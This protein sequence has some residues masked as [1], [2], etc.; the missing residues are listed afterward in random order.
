MD[1]NLSDE[2]AKD[3]LT[4]LVAVLFQEAELDY[5]GSDLNFSTSC[6]VSLLKV[7]HGETYIMTLDFLK[8]EKEAEEIRKKEEKTCGKAD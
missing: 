2:V 5:K 8:R 3:R 1:E 4:T 6:I 7:W